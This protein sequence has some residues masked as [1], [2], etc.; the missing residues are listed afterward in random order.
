MYFSLQPD[1]SSRTHLYHISFTTKT[2]NFTKAYMLMHIC[3]YIGLAASLHLI[4]YI[5]N[6]I[7]ICT[8]K[9]LLLA[10]PFGISIR[11][12]QNSF[13]QPAR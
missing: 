8:P 10:A 11:T 7:A 6:E 1:I 5:E 2:M 13:I 3:R 4:R 9:T 12:E